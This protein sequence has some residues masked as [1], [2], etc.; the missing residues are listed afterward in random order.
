MRRPR[1]ACNLSSDICEERNGCFY[2]LPSI[3]SPILTEFSPPQGASRGLCPQAPAHVGS[4]RP[5][6]P[7]GSR[8][9]MP[10]QGQGH[11]SARLPRTGMR[12]ANAYRE[13]AR[14]V[15][16]KQEVCLLKHTRTLFASTKKR[17]SSPVSFNVSH[18]QS[19]FC[20]PL[21]GKNVG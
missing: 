9:V 5:P 6:F 17:A 18:L 2:H 20:F 7:A 11:L 13:Q 1:P 15:R 19:I 21:M 12:E 3:F 14:R 4:P 10:N 16:V 8:S